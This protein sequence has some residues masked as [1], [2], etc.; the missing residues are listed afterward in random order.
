LFRSI[1][2]LTFISLEL[3]WSSKTVMDRNKFL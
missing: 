2:Y 1:T 3:K